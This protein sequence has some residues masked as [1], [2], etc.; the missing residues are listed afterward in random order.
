M[1]LRR[2]PLSAQLQTLDKRVVSFKRIAFE[3]I[4]QLSSAAG[5]CQQA[6]ARV[7]VLFIC[8]EVRGEVHNSRGKKGY[9]NF[10]RTCVL[11]VEAVFLDDCLF[12]YCVVIRH[13]Y[14]FLCL[15]AQFLGEE[16]SSRGFGTSPKP[17]SKPLFMRNCGRTFLAA[18]CRAIFFAG[19]GM[20]SENC[21]MRFRKIAKCN[22]KKS[23]STLPNAKAFLTLSK[24]T[25]LFTMC[26]QEKN[27][28]VM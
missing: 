21:G 14:F 17:P 16:F 12:I 11:V 3:V 18:S 27:C 1:S 6:A 19:C 23:K 22:R 2:Q 28:G 13:F 4:K 7:E 25:A 26:A 24:H 20:Q 10:A 9:L 15:S 8:R 5:H